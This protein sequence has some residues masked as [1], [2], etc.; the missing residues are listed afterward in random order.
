MKKKT[1][2]ALQSYLMLL[3]PIIGFCAF[4]VYP[5]IWTFKW[6]LYSYSGIPSKAIF[7][8]FENFKNILTTDFTYWKMWI[9]TL[10]FAICKIPFEMIIAM[11][12]ALLL[13]KK[14]KAKG[15]FRSIY[16]LPNVIS[17]A[18]IG[19]I[20]SNMFSPFGFINTSLVK[21]GLISEGFDWYSTKASAITVLVIAS[22]WNTFGVNVMYFM[23][24]LSNV[25]EDVYEAATV[26]GAGRITTFFKI[27][28]PLIAPVM[29]TI[30]LLSLIGTLGVNELIL[31]L[32]GGAPGGETFSVM[33]Y[34]TRKFVPGFATDT[35]LPLG[36]GCAMSLLTTIILTA[37][38][39]AYNKFSE[40]MKNI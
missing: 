26:D 33:S 21:M 24:A 38:A 25:S 40:K 11:F 29:Q 30:L 14:L 10:I 27:T 31:V 5:I 15:L 32:T 37:I 17:I 12:T 20:F 34:V 18:V 9:N 39:I 28:L 8:G 6:S 35:V 22:I 7:I 16:F 13:S 1:S 36:Y 4:S 2:I 3:L 23:A 19:L